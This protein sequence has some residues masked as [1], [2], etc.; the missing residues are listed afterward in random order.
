MARASK[1]PAAS[2]DGADKLDGVRAYNDAFNGA[3]H[4]KQTLADNKHT[5]GTH[6]FV[7]WERGCKD[8]LDYNEMLEA[9]PA[10]RE[11]PPMQPAPDAPTETERETAPKKS[12]KKAAAPEA[13]PVTAGIFDMPDMPGLPN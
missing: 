6:L 9:S 4:G 5:P 8:G 13:E 2:G 11:A 3:R 7:Q 12:R 10:P 1:T